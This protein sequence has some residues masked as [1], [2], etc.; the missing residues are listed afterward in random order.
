MGFYEAYICTVKYVLINEH[1]NYHQY[2]DNLPGFQSGLNWN[3]L[4]VE[5]LYR[6]FSARNL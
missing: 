1:M 5:N 4:I 6:M 3:S 2:S